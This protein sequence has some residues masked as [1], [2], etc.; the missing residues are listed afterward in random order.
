MSIAPHSEQKPG[1]VEAFAPPGRGGTGPPE[2]SAGPA[3]AT[4]PLLF[5]A[6]P[7]SRRPPPLHSVHSCRCLQLTLGLARHTM[8]SVS[9]DP[10]SLPPPP[11]DPGL[12]RPAAEAEADAEADALM[13]SSKSGSL[14]AP[15]R[16]RA[17]STSCRASMSRRFDPWERAE[18]RSGVGLVAGAGGGGGQT[19]PIAT[20]VERW[21]WS[22][23]FS[24]GRGYTGK[25]R[26]RASAHA[27][28]RGNT[29]LLHPEGSAA[30][31]TAVRS[32]S[33]PA[34][35]C[36]S[37]LR[38]QSCSGTPRQPPPLGAQRPPTARAR[39]RAAL[40]R[41]GG[42]RRGERSGGRATRAL[43]LSRGACGKDSECQLQVP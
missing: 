38:R 36:D 10:S 35:P 8:Q 25:R 30:G 26:R 3:P 7:R 5:P 32:C 31:G 18:E 13:S 29:R 2:A 24:C 6:A 19:L 20:G 12:T 15:R 41:G 33:A 11:P 43:Q 21:R 9:A 14:A 16:G 42:G 22:D 34:T 39:A 17:P 1:G 23:G 4:A 40:R 28:S 37:M 27:H